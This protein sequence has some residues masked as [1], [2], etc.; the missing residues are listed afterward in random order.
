[1]RN[2]DRVA[3]SGDFDLA[4]AGPCGIP[5]FE[6]GVDRS[7]ASGYQHPAWFISPR[8]RGDDSFEILS[9]V[10]HLGSCHEGGLLRREIGCEVFMKLL[11]VEVGEA[12]GCLLYRVRLAE[13][14]G[15]ALSVVRLIFSRVW[16]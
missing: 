3:G 7:V 8:R 12:V 10:Q 9:L 13:V 15:E 1:M 16:H 2:V 14:A 11:R 4:A 5:T 6:I